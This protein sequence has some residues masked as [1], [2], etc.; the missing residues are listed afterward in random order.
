MTA[1]PPFPA[2]PYQPDDGYDASRFAEH[3]GAIEQ[4]PAA[5][6]QAVAGLSDPQL[7]TRYRNW[8]VRQI[9]NHL[10]DS[11]AN[12]YVRLKRALTE[13]WPTIKP[14]DEGRWAE[15]AD[16]HC[17]PIEPALSLLNAGHVRWLALL[18]VMTP[19]QFGRESFHSETGKLVSL[20]SA[21]GSYAWHG[22]HHTAQI[23][24][25]RQYSSD[26]PR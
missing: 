11:H 19:G 26:G 5:L 10:A 17:G 20:W 7:D 8:T 1:A 6:R 9:V 15:L 16:S 3:V 13:D 14:Y 4:A 22:R 18:R 25:L 12:A 24:W 23:L 21:I 2:G